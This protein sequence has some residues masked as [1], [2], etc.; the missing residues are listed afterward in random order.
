MRSLLLAFA[1][2]VMGSSLTFAAEATLSDLLK[3][4]TSIAV[5][6][7][8]TPSA[9]PGLD[10]RTW[11]SQ[12]AKQHAQAKLVKVVRGYLP[13]TFQIENQSNSILTPGRH[14]AFLR[15]VEEG[16]Y[17]L[18]TPG[19]LRRIQDDQIYWFGKDFIPLDQALAQIK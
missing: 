2:A 16:R 6:D 14:L 15:R 19:S 3:E 5:V 13:E 1:L 10:D 9:P 8:E 18:S 17:I 11:R 12:L 4:S 7:I